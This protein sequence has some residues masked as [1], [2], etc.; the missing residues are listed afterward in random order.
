M[1]V[2]C[3]GGMR[4]EHATIDCLRRDWRRIVKISN[5]A[6]A[7]I[8]RGG[9]FITNVELFWHMVQQ[10][11]HT[12]SS[13]RKPQRRY[14]SGARCSG[15]W[16]ARTAAIF[17]SIKQRWQW[18]W[19]LVLNIQDK[20]RKPWHSDTKEINNKPRAKPIGW[21]RMPHVTKWQEHVLVGEGWVKL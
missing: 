4:R 8:G 12:A 21:C 13:P 16:V 18:K 19:L 9:E 17:G 3:G 5:G 6:L 14:I 15:C 11:T 10:W 2:D 20:I 1:G 7:C